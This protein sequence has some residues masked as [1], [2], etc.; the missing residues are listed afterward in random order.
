MSE[1]QER[2]CVKEVFFFLFPTLHSAPRAAIE[3]AVITDLTFM[4]PAVRILRGFSSH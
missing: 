1:H 4:G 2:L 3:V